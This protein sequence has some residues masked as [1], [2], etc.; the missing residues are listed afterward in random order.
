MNLSSSFFSA[1]A[2]AS[3]AA[4][5]SLDYAFDLSPI[6]Q[7]SALHMNIFSEFVNAAIYLGFYLMVLH[8]R[9]ILTYPA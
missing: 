5:L 2:A 6:W 9:L 1:A 7:G 4:S 3:A 8:S